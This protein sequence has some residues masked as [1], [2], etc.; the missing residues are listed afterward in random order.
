MRV[1]IL[2]AGLPPEA[3][4]GA[5]IA[6]LQLA[7]CAARLGHEM[8]IITRGTDNVE[9]NGVTVHTVPTLGIG[10]TKGVACVPWIVNKVRRIKPDLVHAQS[11]IM[12]PGAIAV[13]LVLGTAFLLYERGGVDLD[14]ALN[15]VIYPTV[16]R[17]ADRVVAQTQNQALSL[18][19]YH[20]RPVEVIPNGVGAGPAISK[21]QARQQVGLPPDGRIVVAVGRCRPE[22]NYSDF[23]RASTLVS[24]KFVLVG[25][26]PQTA[27]LQA[28]NQD[29]CGKVEFVGGVDNK[30]AWY[31]MQ[32]ADML[33]NTS[34]S[35]GFPMA[36]LEAMSCGIPVVVPN[37]CGLPE[38]VEEGI[39]GML[40][41]PRD[42]ISTVRCI[43]YLLEH[44]DVAAQMG[45]NNLEKARQYTWENV[46]RRLYS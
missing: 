8:H 4:G 37:V 38:I 40:S 43:T 3:S 23:V 2:T 1:V 21:A 31:Y 12:A 27:M 14:S 19:R 29:M 32:A 24:A 28:L 34:F 5:E 6:A 10:W 41:R 7:E 17:V 39:N 20:Y 44:R 35:E 33:V 45:K 9:I 46:V 42:P 15:R 18:K 13:K 11:V 30:T 22:K 16:L 36:V 26:G 25:D